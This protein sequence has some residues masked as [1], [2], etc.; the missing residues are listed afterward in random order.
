VTG[1]GGDERL[2]PLAAAGPAVSAPELVEGLAL[3]ARSEAA[4][5]PFVAAV[6]IASADGRAAVAGRSVGLG[7][8]ADR[9]LLRSL[10]AGV[11]AV[12]VGIGTIRAERYANLLDPGQRAAREAT[13][14]PPVPLIA[15]ISRR[16]DVPWEVGLFGEPDARVLVFTEADL[17]PPATAAHV[18]VA[19]AIAPAE[20]L[21]RLHAE[22]GV[23][24]VLCEGGPTLLRA[25]V[26]ED[27]VDELFL[28]VAPLLAAG[29]ATAPLAGPPLDPPARLALAATHRAGDHLF[30]HYRTAR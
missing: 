10:R 8:P 26:A 20:V 13:G 25:L 21:T 23:R 4:G 18:D 1:A 2:V 5:R 7:H 9:A 14:L 24:A 28:T 11:D 27:L 12:L 16:G 29:D 3:R 17:E 30:L 15:T 22:H 6:M 19:H